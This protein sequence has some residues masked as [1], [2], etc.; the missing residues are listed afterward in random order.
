VKKT[1]NKKP[2]PET[3]L[4]IDDIDFTDQQFGDRVLVLQRE[5]VPRKTMLVHAG[6]QEIRCIWCKR[7][8]PLASAE[9]IGD[10]WICEDCL[11]DMELSRKY[12]GQRR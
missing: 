5:P 3:E 12:G 4:D 1:G 7:I 11:S 6:A 9:E 10:G 2:N 8:K